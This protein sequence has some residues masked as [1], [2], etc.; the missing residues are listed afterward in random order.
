VIV[1]ESCY[2]IVTRVNYF[3]PQLAEN[4]I[5]N[6]AFPFLL[7]HEL[8]QILS[9]SLSASPVPQLIENIAPLILNAWRD[10]ERRGHDYGVSSFEE[11]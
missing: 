2:E 6:E 9:D 3:T 11:E 5:V 8:D 10:L 4:F 1:V 7:S